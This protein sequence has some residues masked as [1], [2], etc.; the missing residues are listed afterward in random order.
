MDSFG[1]AL[2][3]CRGTPVGAASETWSTS[4]LLCAA[5]TSWP[6]PI[7]AACVGDG[8]G[9]ASSSSSTAAM[10]DA[11]SRE[12]FC[13]DELDPRCDFAPL[14]FAVLVADFTDALSALSS[15]LSSTADD[16]GLSFD[17]EVEILERTADPIDRRESLVSDLLNDGYDLKPASF[18]DESS[19]NFLSLD[20]W[21]PILSKLLISRD[22][23]LE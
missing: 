4:P 17:V 5:L 22:D 18:D 20:G 14:D 19:P 16:R 15:V 10:A 13:C 8:G 7:V 2:E 9:C 1:F 12:G 6:F 3:S 23:V 11:V 21:L